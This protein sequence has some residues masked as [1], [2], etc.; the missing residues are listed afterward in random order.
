MDASALSPDAAPPANAQTRVTGQS[1]LQLWL[2]KLP[3]QQLPINATL[4]RAIKTEINDIDS[5]SQRLAALIQQDPPLT[6]ALFATAH[7]RMTAKEGDIQSLSHLISLLGINQLA[8]LITPTPTNVALPRGQRELF[9]ASLFAAELSKVLL[10]LK[11]GTLG[12]RFYLPSLLY[13]TPLWLMWQTAPKLM[14]AIQTAASEKQQALTTLCQQKIGFTLPRLFKKIDAYIA[15]PSL[16]QKALAIDIKQD[17]RAW[18]TI[19]QLSPASAAHW[20]DRHSERKQQF[21]AVEMGIYLIHQ[22]VLAVYFDW[23]DKHIQRWQALLALHLALDSSELQVAAK[24][25]ATKLVLPKHLSGSL[26]PSYRLNRLHREAAPQKANEDKR[27]VFAEQTP[28]QQ[29]RET[30]HLDRV[31]PLA[32]G[33]LRQTI[34]PQCCLILRISQHS[35]KTLVTDRYYGFDD[36]AIDALTLNAKNCGQCFQKLLLQPLVLNVSQ[37]NLS[38]IKKQLPVPLL[39]YWQLQAC[40]IM[41]LFFKEKPYAI[42]ICSRRQWQLNDHR[43]FKHIGKLLTKTLKQCN[44]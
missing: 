34:N 16:T 21:F 22:Y 18:A 23:Q 39:R 10:P 26:A 44:P 12:E 3:Q 9:A 11:H 1:R 6:L 29:L 24:K 2:S 37:D 27:A 8:S 36:D 32:M 28:L 42:I 19:K 5:T 25:C 38:Q 33:C 41:S 13:Q 17:L 20:F 7:Q 14:H 30:H 35:E 31:L 40:G 43:K 15:L 4:A